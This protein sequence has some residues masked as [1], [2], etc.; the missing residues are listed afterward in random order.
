MMQ[1]IDDGDSDQGGSSGGDGNCYNSG[2][3]CGMRKKRDW[4]DGVANN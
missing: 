3:G 2:Y 4:K 1:V